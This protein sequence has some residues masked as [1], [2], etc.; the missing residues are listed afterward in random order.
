[1]KG[2]K[3]DKDL[4]EL[5]RQKLENAEVIPSPSVSTVLMRRLGRN[6]F[7][8]FN[9]ARFNIWYLGGIVAAGAALAI[10][11]SSRSGNND[12]IQPQQPA[13]EINEIVNSDNLI[14]APEQPVLQNADE[15]NK[16]TVITDRKPGVIQSEVDNN[17]KGGMNNAIRGNN[18]VSPAGVTG[19]MPKNGLFRE[20][21]ADK[22]KLQ[23]G[24]RADGCLIESSVTEG[25]PPLRVKFSS[26][27]GSNGTCRWTFGDGGYS[28]E[29]DP[30]WIFDVEGEYEVTL[31]VFDSNK[32][33]SVS[34]IIIT[35]RPKPKALFEISPENAIIP[36]DEIR[37]LNFSSGAVKFRWDF[38]DGNYSEL[39]EPVHSYNKFD[40][41]NVHLV[42][43][44]EYGCSDSLIVMNA[45]AG[46][47]YFIKFPNAFIPNPTGPSGGYYSTKSDEAAQV[48]HPV[49]SGVADYQLKIFS[50]LG[51]LIFESNDVNIGW[52]GYFKG[53][54]SES[55]VY[56]W[57]VRGNFINGEPFTKMGDV[58]LLKN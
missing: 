41:Y 20:S 2:K 46:S 28:N 1:M 43:F 57:K 36:I 13:S 31:N 17:L 14:S 30:E 52:D 45:F 26:K 42:V 39:Y 47:G 49:Q 7:L 55:G 53:Q 9:P 11:L 10:I 8:H 44:S 48:F 38:G 54:L 3:E 29:T 16:N 50:K 19:T 33:L 18:N 27:A 56:I 32:L 58:T 21:I 34:S 35:V 24:Y 40:K 6:E 22:D 15:N 25:C 12:T 51:I 4:R 37:F 23:S 5:F